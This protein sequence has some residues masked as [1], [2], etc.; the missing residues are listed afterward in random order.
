MFKKAQAGD[1]QAQYDLGKASYKT[2]GVEKDYSAGEYYI[3]AIEFD[4]EDEA[5]KQAT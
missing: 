3:Q 1:T 4:Y 5:A 2:H